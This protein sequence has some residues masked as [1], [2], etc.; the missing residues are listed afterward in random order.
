MGCVCISRVGIV[1]ERHHAEAQLILYLIQEA[2]YINKEQRENFLL[3]LTFLTCL[4]VDTKKCMQ[5]NVGAETK[6]AN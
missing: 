1:R 3:P 5:T 4:S 6:G 2:L